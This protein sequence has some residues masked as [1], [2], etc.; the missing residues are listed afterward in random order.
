MSCASRRVTL[1]N[2]VHHK[3]YRITEGRDNMHFKVTQFYD[4]FKGYRLEFMVWMDKF[5]ILSK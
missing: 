3:G 5:K 2:A 4:K 1:H